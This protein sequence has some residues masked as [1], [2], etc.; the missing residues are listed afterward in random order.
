[1]FCSTECKKTAT[2]G[3]HSY[4]CNVDGITVDGEILS[5]RHKIALKHLFKALSWFGGSIELFYEFLCTCNGKTIFDFDFSEMF[6]TK[7]STISETQHLV[8]TSV[9]AGLIMFSK[10]EYQSLQLYYKNVLA[11]YPKM[12]NI[13]LFDH[14]NSIVHFIIKQYQNVMTAEIITTTERRLWYGGV[15]LLRQYMQHSCS[16]NTAILSEK[17]TFIVQEP[18]KKGSLMTVNHA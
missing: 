12:K 2:E 7:N 10:S 15:F 5:K 3:Y 11:M 9:A 18:I 1:M 6:S 13:I 16:S 4:E 14:F 8:A 17:L